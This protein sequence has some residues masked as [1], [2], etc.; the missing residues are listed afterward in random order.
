MNGKK[1]VFYGWFIV[2]SCVLIMALAYAPLVSCASLFITP[3]TE[4]LGFARSAYTLASSISTLVM[5]VLSPFVGKI[6]SQKCMHKVLVISVAG[7]AVSYGM[8][9]VANTLAAFYIIAVFVGIFASAST[10]LP[11]SIVITN[12]FQKQRGLAMSI[13]MAGSGIGGALLSPIIA[14]LITE[15]GWRQ[16][17]VILAVLMFVVLVPVAALIIRQKP[18]DKGLVP[19][20]YGEN[21]NVKAASKEKEWN[22]SLKELRK[23]S[24]FWM[25]I[26][27]IALISV[28]GA[29]ISHIP[30]A[31]T[32]AGYSAAKAASIV[33][34]YL[35]IAVPGKLVLGHVFDK[36]GAKAGILFGNTAFILAVIMLLFIDR[37]EM[38]LYIMAVIFGFG[39]CI[40]TVSG[41]VL[42]SK[43][44]GAEHYAETYGFV[45]VFVNAGF[46]VGSPMIAAT[47]DMTGSYHTAWIIVAVLAVLMTVLLLSSAVK[48]KQNTR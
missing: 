33:S 6:M 31:I 47:Y 32:D 25:F 42:T 22:V 27:G 20:G 39:T 30:S 12:W 15:Q 11:V 46:A 8:F 26:I 48:A 28:T 43:L 38:M 2:V 1:K 35:A 10:M 34:L 17:Y 21:S 29:I 40:G 13:A 14:K 37:S 24:V 18:E 41:S 9:S 7:V 45:S 36:Y 16:T 44:F 3:I 4:D 23:M 5:I 19:Y